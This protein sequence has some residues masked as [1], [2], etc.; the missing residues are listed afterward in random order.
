MKTL[1]LYTVDGRVHSVEVD[2]GR[3]EFAPEKIPVK[4]PGE[5][6]VN[7]PITVEGNTYTVTCVN[8][9]NPHCVMFCQTLEDVD[10]AGIGRAL[11][12][13]DIFPERVNTSFVRVAD[14][15]TL[16]MRV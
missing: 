13:A 2:V 16:R 10:V 3:V 8:V 15:R 6:I 11:E 4:L 7:C 9:G 5:K 14:R 12:Y 1:K